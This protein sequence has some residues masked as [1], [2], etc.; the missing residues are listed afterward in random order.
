MLCNK[1]RYRY[2]D[3]YGVTVERVE[4]PGDV[5]AQDA[6]RDACVI[7]RQPA[8][9]GLLRAV[10]QEQVV[11]HRTQHAHLRWKHTHHHGPDHGYL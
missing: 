4:D 8:T 10:A 7:Q 2:R 11:A 6:H 1:K 5:A 3:T 9:A